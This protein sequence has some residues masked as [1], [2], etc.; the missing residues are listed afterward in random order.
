MKKLFSI[1]PILLLALILVGCEKTVIQENEITFEFINEYGETSTKTV[2]YS[3]EF[4][5]SFQDLMTDNFN[6]T[7]NVGDFGAM[8]LGIE[9]LDPKTGA[10]I[11]ISKN[12]V[13]SAV[14]IDLIEYSNGDTFTFEVIWWDQLEQS[15]DAAIQ[16]FL[17]NQAD[18]FVNE[19]AIDYMVLLALELLGLT[20]EFVTEE[21][22]FAIVEGMTLATTADFFKAV[23]LLNVADL[24]IDS[25]L[26]DFKTI[27]VPGFYGQTAYGLLTFDSR[28][29]SVDYID[30]QISAIADLGSNTPYDQGLDSGGI[31]IVA[32]SNYSD[33]EGVPALIADYAIWI[34]NSQLEFGGVKTRDMVWGDT[35]YPGTENASSMAQVIMGLI[36]NNIDPT[37]ALF[38]K[39]EHNLI[40]RLLE[41]QTDTGSFDYILTDETPEDLFFSTPQAFLALVVYQTYSNNFEAVNPYNFN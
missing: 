18:D 13:A 21:E 10:Y 12:D 36:A 19:N 17:E 31:S 15:V 4:E 6:F 14:G 11:S 1:V 27:A 39:G 41:F 30:F 26:Q 32:L 16:L 24:S 23:M 9:G 38:S 22:I 5:G 33:E 29:T 20:D 8:L 37:G 35:T 25:Y 7:F 2:N 28:E 40:A 34:S 3:E